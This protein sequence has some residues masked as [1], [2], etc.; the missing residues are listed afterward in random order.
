MELGRGACALGHCAASTAQERG[1]CVF[2]GWGGG[3][4]QHGVSPP[5]EEGR[6]RTGVGWGSLTLMGSGRNSRATRLHMEHEKHRCQPRNQTGG[7]VSA[8][9]T[10]VL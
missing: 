4:Q 2:G 6:G 7:E 8:L 3:A 5:G 1:P 10:E 9:V